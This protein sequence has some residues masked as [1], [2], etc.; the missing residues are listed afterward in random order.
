VLG[1]GRPSHDESMPRRA[2]V[3]SRRIE[4]RKAKPRPSLAQE[5]KLP[6]AEEPELINAASPSGK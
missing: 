2:P 6:K 3:K 4:P 5:I 1:R